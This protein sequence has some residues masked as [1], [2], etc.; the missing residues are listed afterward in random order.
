MSP[1]WNTLNK[2]HKKSAVIEYR[3]CRAQAEQGKNCFAC[4]FVCDKMLHFLENRIIEKS[5]S[6]IYAF[7]VSMRGIK[8]KMLNIEEKCLKINVRRKPAFCFASIQKL[9]G[10]I[11]MSYTKIEGDFHYL[12]FRGSKKTWWLA[13]ERV[14]KQFLNRL[15]RIREKV[16]FRVYAFCI[17][18][19]EAHFLLHPLKDS[20]IGQ[21][22][23]AMAQELQESYLSLYPCGKEEVETVSKRMVFCGS[24]DTLK[25]CCYIHMLARGYA[26]RIQDYWWSSYSEY[27]HK[28]VTGLVET[29]TVLRTLDTNPHRALQKFVQYHKKYSL[30]IKNVSQSEI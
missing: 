21:T 18:D 2:T 8:K 24:E 13:D 19:Q 30:L 10:R 16:R 7:C 17:L 3:K 14:K 20:G 26:E 11:F 1:V 25:Y 5:P 4:S 22:S 29:E 27:L 15:L 6:G 9:G 28:N 23:D 12:I